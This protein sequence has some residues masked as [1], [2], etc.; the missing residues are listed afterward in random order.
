MQ[1]RT[2][3]VAASLTMG[4]ASAMAQPAAPVVGTSGIFADGVLAAAVH[5]PDLSPKNVARDR[6]RH[7]RESLSFWGLKPGTKIIEI[8]PGGGDWAEILLPY[9]KATNGEYI[10]AIP[11][12]AQTLPA[13]F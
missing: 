10:A 8:W 4:L 1:M 3:V 2:L 5:S 12:K 9:A 6:Y 7:P 13:K 11:E